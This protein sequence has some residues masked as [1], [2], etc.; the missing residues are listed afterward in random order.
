[1]KRIEALLDT[2]VQRGGSDLLLQAGAEPMI[3]VDGALVRLEGPAL[4][5]DQTRLALTELA[6][7]AQL[8]TL[9]TERQPDFAFA[10]RDGVRL[11]ANAFYQRS[12]ISIALRSLPRQ[13][14]T[15]ASL[16]LPELAAQFVQLP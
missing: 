6:T 11:R 3:R 13:I 16:G 9:E 15:F 2:L 12:A 5:P 7:P 10:W 1:M 14:P 4:T 8:Q